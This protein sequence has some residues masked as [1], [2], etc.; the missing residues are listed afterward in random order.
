MLR[1]R[2][3]GGTK[4]WQALDDQVV[5]H[6]AKAETGDHYSA[7]Q[8]SLARKPF[9]HHRHRCHVT[10]ADSKTAHHA[11]GQVEAA[12]AQVG[13]PETGERV[14]RTP[15]HGARERNP[16]RPDSVLESSARER[17]QPQE[18]DREGERARRRRA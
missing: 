9:G 5:D 7:S 17:A 6:R 10:H 13:S 12:C 15:E 3:C 18:E 4:R 16:A 14:A 8:A 11:V 1:C 2:G